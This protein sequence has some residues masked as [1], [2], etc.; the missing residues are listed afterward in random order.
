LLCDLVGSLRGAMTEQ[1]LLDPGS[2]QVAQ[3]LISAVLELL[4]LAI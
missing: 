4:E 3:E 1:L 2:V